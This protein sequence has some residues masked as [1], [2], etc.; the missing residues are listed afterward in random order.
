MTILLLLILGFAAGI[1]NA[2]LQAYAYRILP[3]DMRGRAFS[4]LGALSMISFPVGMFIYG[5]LLAVLPTP[6]VVALLGVPP[7]MAGI[8]A[9]WN[10]RQA[11]VEESLQQRA[12][13]RI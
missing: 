3:A 5:L 11:A 2:T 10:V 1:M 9:T 8:V 6:I 7:I 13:H 12:Q 4:I